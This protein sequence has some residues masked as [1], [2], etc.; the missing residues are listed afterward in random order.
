MMNGFYLIK[1]VLKVCFPLTIDDKESLSNA[2]NKSNENRS[3]KRGKTYATTNRT[4]IVQ[5]VVAQDI[6]GKNL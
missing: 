6:W 4:I 3:I 2:T 5:S 1:E